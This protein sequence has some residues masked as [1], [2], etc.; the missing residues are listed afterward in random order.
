MCKLHENLTFVAEKL[1][2]IKLIESSVLK[3][4]VESV[5]CSSLNT[6]C[7]YGECEQ[8]KNQTVP[9]SSL[10]AADENVVFLQWMVKEKQRKNE[11]GQTVKVTVKD[12]VNMTQEQLV[13]LF[14]TLL[15]RFRKHIF[16]IKQ[17]YAYCRE[18]K[19]NMSADECLIHIDFSENFTCRYGT[20]IQSVHFGS[21]HEQA[22]LHTGVLYVG[23]NQQPTCFTTISPSRNKAPPAIWAHLSP[24]LDDLQHTH[25]N[26]STVHFFSDGP[27]TQYRQKGNLFMFSTELAKRGLRAGFWNFF[28]AGHGK[29]APDGVG[30]TLKR[31]ADRLI[32]QGCDIPNAHTLYR[33]LEENNTAIKLYFIEDEAIEKAV[34]GMPANLPVVPSTMRIHQVVCVA[35]RQI[36]YRDVSCMCAQSTTRN[37]NASV[38]IHNISH[39]PLKL[40]QSCHR[41]RLIGQIQTYAGNGAWPNMKTISFPE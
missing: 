34:Q 30:A 12:E 37:W 33:V 21:S 18:L 39:L 13:Q 3:D 35:A 5:C 41:G 40:H 23:Q 24:V 25:P 29:G 6:Q 32:S 11:E 31:T 9:M 28:E 14:H 8:C 16:N 36:A 2:Q 20:E 7:M 22:V 27:C 10:Y 17:Q 15:F 26:I 1:K 38:S 4:L 19:K